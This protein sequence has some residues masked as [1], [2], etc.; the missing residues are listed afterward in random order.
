MSL[1][2]L[3][4]ALTTVPAELLESAALEGANKLQVFFH[5][6]LPCISNFVVLVVFHTSHGCPAYV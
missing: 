2:I 6:T 4:A 1:I 3:L 5:V